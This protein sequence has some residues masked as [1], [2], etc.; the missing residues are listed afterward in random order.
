MKRWQ[1]TVCG[2]I[3]EGD[4]PPVPCPVCSA[5]ES[6]FIELPEQGVTVWRC[7]VCGQIFTG[8]NPPVPCPICGAGEGA[9]VKETQKTSN[10]A[11][12]TDDKFV[13]IGG[14]VAGFE[15]AKAIRQRNKT[16]DIALICG[17][18]VI[19][20]NRP[21][22]SDVVG[23]GLS[24]ETIVLAQ[25]GYYAENNI[26]LICDGAATDINTADKTVALS[27]GQRLPYTKLLIATGANPFVP[28]SQGENAVS[29]VSLR[30]FTDA[31]YLYTNAKNKS[32]VIVGGGIL[33]V[34]AALALR[35][36]GCKITIVEHAQR[37]MAMQAD[38]YASEV[39]AKRF[40]ELGIKVYTGATVEKTDAQGACLASGEHLKADLILA[41]VGVR[42]ETALAVKAGLIVNRG[43]IIDE[44][45][46]TSSQDIFAAGDCAEFGGKVSG[47]YAAAAAGG[48]NAGAEM[49]GEELIYQPTAPATAFEGAG[50][51]L[52]STGQLC[53]ER[54]S[55]LVYEDK[56]NGVYKRL[57]FVNKKLIGGILLGDTS[58]A[59]RLIG[60]VTASMPYEK[61]VDLLK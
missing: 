48:Q 60:A 14:G 3:F 15:A 61:A 26:S 44:H 24:F 22:L 32:V 51:S 45:M 28:I 30:N 8:A 29:V 59:A 42:S 34:E 9:F 43:I 33:G 56:Y 31:D 2:Q 46:R 5:G 58:A 10:F 54:A 4:L 47:L 17:E 18:G 41:S 37:L 19:P 12:D 21:M 38:E 1:C 23:D 36:R 16:A 11:L 55:D 39:L 57:V 13:I 20:Y 25:Y 40:A 53:A 7:T 49:A 52:F 27:N 50:I 6:A 35:E